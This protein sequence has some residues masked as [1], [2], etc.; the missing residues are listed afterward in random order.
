MLDCTLATDLDPLHHGSKKEADIS[1]IF[2]L[3]CLASGVKLNAE[4]QSVNQMERKGKE[5]RKWTCKEL[6]DDS[7]GFFLSTIGL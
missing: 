3:N 5:I 4:Y 7:P 2:I 1:F 6:K